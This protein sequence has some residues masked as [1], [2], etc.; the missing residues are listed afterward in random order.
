ML[1]SIEV[2]ALDIDN[3]KKK[4]VLLLLDVFA[5]DNNNNKKKRV[6]VIIEVFALDINNN[7]N[8]RVYI[9]ESRCKTKYYYQVAIGKLINPIAIHQYPF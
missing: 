5:L 8:K 2:F 1:L 7:N 9:D 3:N 4:R 6:L